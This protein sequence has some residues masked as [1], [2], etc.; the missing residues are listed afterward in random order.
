[1][2]SDRQRLLDVYLN[3]HLAGAGLGTNLARRMVTAGRHF[4]D[5]AAIE[6]LAAEIADDRASLVEIMNKLGIPARRRV[7]ALGYLAEKAGR[8]KPNGRVVH[9][10]PLSSLLELEML[11]AGVE[12]KAS[13]WRALRTIADS[14]DRL[15]KQQLDTLIE[16]AEHQSTVL[17]QLHHAHTT[18][19]FA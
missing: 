19:T 14:D 8:L 4:T 9:R 1:M 12:G 18:Q 5:R 11:R 16:R 15:D 17:Q 2:P 6:R 10:S 3:D 7:N 13:G